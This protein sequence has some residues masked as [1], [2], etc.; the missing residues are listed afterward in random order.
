MDIEFNSL[1]ELY[2][3]LKPALNTKVSEM[4]RKG[5]TYI[6]Q[7]DIWNY[8]KEVKWKTAIDLNLYQMVSDLLNTDDLLIDDYLKEKLKLSNRKIYFEED[9]HE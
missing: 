7:E 2:E 4:H 6:K 1:K 8:F 3:R 5:F 9:R